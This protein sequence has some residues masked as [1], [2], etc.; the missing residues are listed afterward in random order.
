MSTGHGPNPRLAAIAVVLRGEEVLLVRR[1][2]PPNLGAWGF[3]GGKVH[4]GESVL[5][6]AERELREETGLVG[7]ARRAFDAVDVVGDA[8]EDGGPPAHHFCLVAVR[9]DWQAETP[10]AGPVA[11]PVAG[12]DA[13]ATGW[14]RHDALPTPCV[15]DVA[16]IIATASTLDEQR[17]S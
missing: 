3:P 4:Y 10:D 2:T 1:G 13:Q 15:A 12:D 5:A 7:S 8:L 16:R 9:V 6:A 14:F 17:T 11:G